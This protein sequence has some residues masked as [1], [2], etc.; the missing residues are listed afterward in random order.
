MF[1]LAQQ[2]D[3]ETNDIFINR[4]RG[5]I[6]V[7]QYGELPDDLLIDKIIGSVKDLYAKIF[8]CAKELKQKQLKEI[9]TENVNGKK[10]IEL[11]KC[12]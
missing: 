10:C 5:L 8:D 12:A 9:S 1:K 2:Y 3:D 11:P 6:K 7:C 4:L